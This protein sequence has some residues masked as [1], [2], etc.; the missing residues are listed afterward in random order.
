MRI[1]HRLLVAALAVLAM[2]MPTAAQAA[3]APYVVVL[4]PGADV[5]KAVSKAKGVGA[6]VSQTYKFALNG[7]AANIPTD[8]VSVI[9]ADT[10]VAFV[11]ADGVFT[12]GIKPPNKCTSRDCQNP[13]EGILRIDADESSTRAGDGQGAVNL[14]VAVLDS[15]V[16][17]HSDLN[18]AGG[19]ACS[20]TKSYADDAY[21]GTFVAGIIAA[22]DNN[23]GTVGVAPGARIW[24]VKVLN[25]YGTGS[26][27]SILCGVDW[28][29]STRFDSDPANDIHVANMSLNG[30][31]Q[32]DGACGSLNNDPIHR[33][34]CAGAQAGVAF[35]ASAG[36]AA[37]DFVGSIPA[38][39]DEVLTATAM[40]DYDGVPGGTGAPP[41]SGCAASNPDD[42][43]AHY[44]NYTTGSEL[45]HTVA[46]PGT[47]LQSLYPGDLYANFANGTSFA[48][49]HAA[50]VLALCISS[51]GC[52]GI[53]G[54]QAAAK[55]RN[56]A[57]AYNNANPRYGFQGDLLRPLG[58]GRIYGPLVHAGS[59]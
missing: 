14:N 37:E 26:A 23:F 53:S 46:A 12:S 52:A 21:H 16:G 41:S 36:N 31:G 56:D 22:K 59:Y 38:N 50:G 10:S 17:P 47:C 1:A 39:Y 24:S 28:V 58:N 34:I 19:K 54:A 33:A 30:K 4:K 25:K 5:T 15:G 29:V 8:K 51:G 11:A 18:I 49:P 9:S 27:S 7:Y 40:N 43:P 35:A 44:S 6:T 48:A 2:M 57:V 13:D 32:D 20:N 45:A 3:T 42:A 55:V